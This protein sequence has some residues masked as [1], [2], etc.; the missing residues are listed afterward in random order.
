MSCGPRLFGSLGVCPTTLAAMQFDKALSVRPLEV[1]V[2]A[3]ANVGHP[4]LGFV[5]H[6]F[7]DSGLRPTDGLQ[8]RDEV[9]PVHASFNRNCAYY[10]SAIAID[11]AITIAI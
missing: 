7:R 2:A 6:R 3:F 9:F 1:S 4:R 5:A 8:I 10:A 11:L